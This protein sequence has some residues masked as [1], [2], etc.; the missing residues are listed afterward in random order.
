MCCKEAFTALKQRE[1]NR[2]FC[3]FTIESM[4]FIQLLN[5]KAEKYISCTT[6]QKQIRL[7]QVHFY[8]S[9]QSFCSVRRAEMSPTSCG[10]FDFVC[11]KLESCR[12]SIDL[13][14]SETQ[15]AQQGNIK[16][17]LPEII[18]RNDE[19]CQPAKKQNKINIYITGDRSVK[20]T[21]K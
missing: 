18:A 12:K 17:S 19:S 14:M 3:H 16:R 4:A 1:N 13:K 8:K 6:Q 7:R 9:F 10:N 2:W 21:W 15:G 11:W 20:N 5:L